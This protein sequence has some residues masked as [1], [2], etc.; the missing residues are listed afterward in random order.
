MFQGTELTRLQERKNLLVAK[1]DA[2]RRVL[3]DEWR[4]LCSPENWMRETG[5]LA[6]KHPA[7]TAI[8]SAVAGALAVQTVRKPASVT[9]GIDRLAKLATMAVTVWRLVRRKK[10]G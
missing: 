10:E 9:G 8:L 7:W 3:A 4:R 1:S 6:R 2:N 5:R